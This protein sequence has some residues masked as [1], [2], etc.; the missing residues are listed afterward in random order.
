MIEIAVLILLV[1]VIVMQ[2]VTL[3]IVTRKPLPTQRPDN[4]TDNAMRE[5]LRREQGWSEG[6]K[7]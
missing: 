1:V 3:C 6:M 4:A 2:A 5:R 7:R